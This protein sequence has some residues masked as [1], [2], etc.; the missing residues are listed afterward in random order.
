MERF[1]KGSIE[2][3]GHQLARRNHFY[4]TKAKCRPSQFKPSL[5][6]VSLDIE[7]SEKERY[8]LLVLDCERDSRVI[9]IGQPS[10]RKHRSNGSPMKK[11]SY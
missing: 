10:Q 8:I 11:P 3:T 5:C 7:C 6:G 9:L 4:I 2:F 1:I